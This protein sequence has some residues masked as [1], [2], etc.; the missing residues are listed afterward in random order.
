MKQNETDESQTTA[1][2]D[3][4]QLAQSWDIMKGFLKRVP[5]K[6][7]PE[8]RMSEKTAHTTGG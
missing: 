5:S 3:N 7:R 1:L 6:L 2:E 8:G 4:G